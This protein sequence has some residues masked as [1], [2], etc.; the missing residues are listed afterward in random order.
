M[1]RTFLAICYGQIKMLVDRNSIN[2]V[3]ESK[4]QRRVYG[5]TYEDCNL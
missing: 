2:G 3:I 1:G 4:M 5:D